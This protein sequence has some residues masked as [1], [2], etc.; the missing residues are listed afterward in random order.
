MS[1]CV[2][3]VSRLDEQNHAWHSHKLLPVLYPQHPLLHAVLHDK[4]LYFHLTLLSH[5]VNAVNGLRLDSETPPRIHHEDSSSTR[6]IKPNAASSQADKQ[7]HK[8]LV[9]GELL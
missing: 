6:K 5:P 3:S 8:T 7:D 4:S 2:L 1:H 9:I